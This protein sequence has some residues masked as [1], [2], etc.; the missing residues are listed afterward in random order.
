MSQ[1]LG[2]RLAL[3]KRDGG[4]ARLILVLADTAWRR[5]VVR[6]NELSG[7]PDPGG[8]AIILI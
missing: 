1:E 4:V 3:K 7:G 2:R 8:D 5:R 6:L